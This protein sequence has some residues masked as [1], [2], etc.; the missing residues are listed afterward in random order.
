M[1]TTLLTKA[2]SLWN[3]PEVSRE[4]NRANMRKWAKSVKMLGSNWLLA[5]PVEKKVDRIKVR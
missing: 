5:V 1:N 2:R 4:L 3:N